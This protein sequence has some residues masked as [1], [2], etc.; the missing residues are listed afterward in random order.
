MRNIKN[1]SKKKVVILGSSLPML[2]LAYFLTR[3][4]INV[5]VINDTNL[6][7]GAWKLFKYQNIKIRSQSNVIVPINKKEENN[8]KKIN[9]YLKHIFQVK[10]NKLNKK[11]ITPY[12]FKNK[13]FYDFKF[14]LKRISKEKIFRKIN[15]K[16]IKLY[17]NQIKIN[18]NF[19]FDFM[20]VPT[21]F[22]IKEFKLNNKIIKTDFKIIQSEHVV[23]L[24]KTKNFN[25]LYYSDFFNDFFDRV[26]FT[27]EKNFSIFSA[28]IT[29]ENKGSN[30]K[31]ILAEIKKLFCNSQIIS[32]KKFSYKNYYRNYNQI[33]KL[34]KI[35]NYKSIKYLD[36]QSFMSFFIEFI[37][38]FK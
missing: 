32:I 2:I 28:R 26:Q 18:N 37:K 4:K 10:I 27:S 22:G 31:K 21:Y 11:I 12:K 36:T 13:F 3:N 14:F 7:G 35:D 5:S 6:K 9:Y 19:N 33:L 24:I 30:T 34:K 23:A 16:E 15:V 38:Y 25:N 1:L 29:K 17:N 20:F 8:Q